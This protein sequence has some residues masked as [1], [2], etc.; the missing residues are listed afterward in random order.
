MRRRFKGPTRLAD[1][2]SVRI[3][4]AIADITSDLQALADVHA[5]LQNS[6]SDKLIDFRSLLQGMCGHFL[7]LSCSD[8]A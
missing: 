6:P 3:R 1:A 5:L 4:E 8:V 2:V 7:R